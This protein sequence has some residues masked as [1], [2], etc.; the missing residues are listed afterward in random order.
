M[1]LILPVKNSSAETDDDRS[2]EVSVVTL[3]LVPQNLTSCSAMCN[4]GLIVS[5]I[6]SRLQMEQTVDASRRLERETLQ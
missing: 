4:C 2:K 1:L 3:V 5:V 6:N